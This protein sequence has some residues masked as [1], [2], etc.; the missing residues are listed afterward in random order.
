[1]KVKIGSNYRPSRFEIRADGNYRCLM[2]YT[3]S[4]LQSALIGS[5]PKLSERLGGVFWAVTGTVTTTA[6]LFLALFV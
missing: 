1:M 2:P 4:V 5:R 3:D 6:L